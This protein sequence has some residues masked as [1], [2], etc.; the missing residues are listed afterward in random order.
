MWEVGVDEL[1]AG[2]VVAD[3]EVMGEC[4]VVDIGE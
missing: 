4:L 1:P 3:V 2:L